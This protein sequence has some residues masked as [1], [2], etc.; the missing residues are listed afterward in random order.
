MDK[1]FALHVHHGGYF[2]ENTQK[3]MGGEVGLVDECDLDKWSKI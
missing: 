2:D 3:Y 1:F